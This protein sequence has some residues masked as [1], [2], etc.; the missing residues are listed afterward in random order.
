MRL[1]GRGRS[2]GK[3]LRVGSQLLD[4]VC[5]M[6][7]HEKRFH[8]DAFRCA[9]LEFAEMRGR[10]VGKGGSS[11]GGLTFANTQTLLAVTWAAAHGVPP[12]GVL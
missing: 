9:F 4:M 3:G 1:F 12:M 5:I 6:S 7:A 11:V 2:V 10:S 8:F